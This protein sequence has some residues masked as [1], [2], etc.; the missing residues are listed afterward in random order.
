MYVC[1]CN[2]ISDKVIRKAIQQHR[3]VN[4][5]Q[6]RQVVPVGNGCGKCLRQTKSILLEMQS[7]AVS[8]VA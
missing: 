1:L 8:A 7:G 3:P 4:L 5:Q 6:L 2:A